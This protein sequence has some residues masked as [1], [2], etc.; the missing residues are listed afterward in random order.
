M[1]G[2][3]EHADIGEAIPGVRLLPKPFDIATLRRELAGWGEHTEPT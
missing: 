2:Y 1:S 3:G